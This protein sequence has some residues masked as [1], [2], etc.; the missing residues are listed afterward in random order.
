[1]RW[2]ADIAAASLVA[3]VG[4]ATAP[5]PPVEMSGDWKTLSGQAVWRPQKEG[6]IAGE[7]LFATNSLG[8]FWVE[9]A[10]PPI[11]IV[12]ARRSADRWQVEFPAQ[13]RVHAGNGPGPAGLIWLHLAPALGKRSNT[14][15]MSTNTSGW[16]IENR[17][18]ESLEGFFAP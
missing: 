2:R 15:H 1:M 10:K 17:K 12:T 18:G 14:W 16:R 11:T 6:G 8:D 13:G 3:W 7:L 4:C 9:F 5:L